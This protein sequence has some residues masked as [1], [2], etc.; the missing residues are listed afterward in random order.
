MSIAVPAHPARPWPRLWT[1]SQAATVSPMASRRRALRIALGLV[2][3]LDAALQ[4]Q[5][6]M[7]SSKFVTQIIEPTAAGNPAVIAHPLTWVAHFELHHIVV[8]NAL[9]ATFQLTLAIGILLARTA[10]AALGTSIVWAV[11]VWWFGE[12]FGGVLT[13]G[14][15]PFMGAP[16][17]VII[18]AFIALLVWPQDP[19]RAMADV[20]TGDVSVATTSRLGRAVPKGLWLAMW[21]SFAYLILQPTNRSPSGLGSMVSGMGSG[22]PGWI[23]S[24]DSALASVLDGRGADVS[25]VVAALCIVVAY[26]VFIHRAARIAVVLAIGLGTAFWTA[27]NFGGVFTTKG[28]DPNSGLLIILL[29]LVYWPLSAT[30]RQPST[31]GAPEEPTSLPGPPP[32][33]AGHV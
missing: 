16:G 8:Y 23:K 28:T 3:L 30:T 4:F 6:F 22:E 1:R 15:S 25:I 21:A 26:G 10:K 12:G 29:A 27:E 11:A 31:S 14:A 24:M 7:F 9:F 2:W 13:G 32:S 5:P 19:E 20:P 17:A 18:Y 33:H